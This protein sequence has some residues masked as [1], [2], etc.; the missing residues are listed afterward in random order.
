MSEPTPSLPGREASAGTAETT[1]WEGRPS[2]WQNFWWWVSIIGIPVAIC[3]HVLLKCTKITL[4]SQRLKISSGLLNKRL[5]EIELYRVKDW[6][7][8]QPLF[9][10]LL[11]YGTVTVI[12][13]DRSAPEVTYRWLR[14]AQG[15]VEK[16]RAAVEAVRDRKRVRALEIDETD[17]DGL[18]QERF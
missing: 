4:T 17:G 10:R 13:S 15:L 14:D 11:G 1:L 6:T 16:L 8:T 18:D 9:Q 5:E 3:K 7:F 2:S 12:S